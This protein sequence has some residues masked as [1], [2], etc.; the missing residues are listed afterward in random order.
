MGIA[1]NIND[2]KRDMP[3]NVRIIAVS[4]YQPVSSI[5]AAYNAGQRDFG[6]NKAQECSDK[7]PQLPADIRWHFIGHLQTNKVR[8]IAPFVHMIHSID[9]LKL[10]VEVNKEAIKNNRTIN[11]LLQFDIAEELTKFGM[12]LPD[13]EEIL[14]CMQYKSMTHIRIC[15]V[16]GMASFTEDMDQVRAEFRQLKKYF[17]KLKLEYFAD[18]RDFKEIS[19]GMSGDYTLAI[20]EGSTMVRIG[21]AIFGERNTH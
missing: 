10:L 5:Q 17:D 11:C 12:S 9:S 7:Q 2:L 18:S 1:G 15:G 20:E 4:K 3:E 8:L 14:N 19:M 16:M 6:E 21:T 13:A